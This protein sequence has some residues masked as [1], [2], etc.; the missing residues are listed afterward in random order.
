M[1]SHAGAESPKPSA[2][3]RSIGKVDIT[4][5]VW[6]KDLID[7]HAIKSSNIK[8]VYGNPP[9]T[10]RYT[11]GAGQRN[12]HFVLCRSSARSAPHHAHGNHVKAPSAPN[13]SVAPQQIIQPFNEATSATK[14][15]KGIE[16]WRSRAS[17]NAPVAKAKRCTTDTAAACW[18]NVSGNFQTA[19]MTAF[20]KTENTP[21]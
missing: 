6:T 15:D 11:N 2:T 12:R 9:V 19:M 16:N 4:L 20:T 18:G 8:T 1:A 10:S 5:R 14:I 3:P 17:K 13:Q 7:S 21:Y